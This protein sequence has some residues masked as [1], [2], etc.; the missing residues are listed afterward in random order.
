MFLLLAR[1]GLRAG[2]VSSLMLDDID[3]Q[4]GS[5]T[6]HGKGGRCVK[7]P[8]PADVGEAIAAYL[9]HAR[10][11]SNTRSVFLSL[12][13]PI[14]S[15]DPSTVSTQVKRSLIL[16]G[17]DSPKQGAHQ[18]RHSLATEMLPVAVFTAE[19]W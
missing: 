1:L 3:W 9:L 7:M 4:E 13:A 8:L 17:I 14:G 18:F 19:N 6:V 15:L 12:K 16:A 11:S 10:P 5:M 2:E